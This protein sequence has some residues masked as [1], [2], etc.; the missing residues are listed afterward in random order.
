LAMTGMGLVIGT[1]SGLFGL[2]GGVITIPFLSYCNVPMRNVVGISIACS[3]TVA[4]IG[5]VGFILTGLHAANLPPWSTGYVYWPAVAG[6]A[7]TSPIFA[8]YGTRLSH[9]LPVVTLK[10]LFALFLILVALHMLLR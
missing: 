7:L 4:I 9:Q 8:R 3:L 6:I 2:G 1:K 10:R 5:T